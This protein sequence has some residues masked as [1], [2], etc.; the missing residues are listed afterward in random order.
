[1]S[2]RNTIC[3]GVLAECFL[4]VRVQQQP[5]RVTRLALGDD[6]RAHTPTLTPV[7]LRK[8]RTGLNDD[9]H[10]PAVRLRVRRT[11]LVTNFKAACDKSNPSTTPHGEDQAYV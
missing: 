6:R 9:R 10:E 2:Y 8:R 1:M 5:R 4:D 7:R 3:V 11:G